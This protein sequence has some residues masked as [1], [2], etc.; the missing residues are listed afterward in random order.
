MGF[1]EG[2]GKGSR[3]KDWAVY[4]SGVE[5]DLVRWDGSLKV[6]EGRAAEE[7]MGRG[8]GEALDSN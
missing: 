6:G 5:G 1:E 3:E 7:G 2:E 4:C 8:Q